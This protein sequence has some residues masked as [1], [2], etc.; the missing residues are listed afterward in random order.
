MD[1]CRS[2]ITRIPYATLIATVMCLIGVGIFCGTMYR[3]AALTVIMFEKVFHQRI[4]WIETLQ[5]IFVIIAAVMGSIGFIVLVMGCLTTG[6][7]RHQVYK[8][9]SSRFSGRLSC[10]IFLVIT[11]ILNIVWILVFCVL[12]ILTFICTVLWN[13]CANPDIENHKTCISLSQFHFLFPAGTN[14]KDMEI[15]EPFDVKILCKDTV[16]IGEVMFILALVSS[17]LVI[18]SL[19]H[20]L[21]CLTA[22]YAHIKDHKKFRELQINQNNSNI[23]N[24]DYSI[25]SKE[26]L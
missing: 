20:Y 25:D 1:C 7:T 21:M 15:C 8:G 10:V 23:Q 2:C 4:V 17:L 3:G 5:V 16:E 18:L 26:Q 19:T 12:A 22:N 14:R 24:F 6:A 13:L 9:L 11:Y